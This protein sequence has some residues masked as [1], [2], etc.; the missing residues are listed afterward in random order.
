MQSFRRSTSSGNGT[1][2][3]NEASAAVEEALN[4]A[5]NAEQRR[6]RKCGRVFKKAQEQ[7]QADPDLANE[8]IAEAEQASKQAEEAADLAAAA[9]ELLDQFSE[10]PLIQ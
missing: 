9:N 2:T 5:D 7:A 10:T 3:Q 4:A 6:C 8:S 1:G